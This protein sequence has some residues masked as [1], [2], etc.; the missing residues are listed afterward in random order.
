MA[1]LTATTS[2]RDGSVFNNVFRGGGGGDHAGLR[3]ANHIGSVVDDWPMY[4]SQ[5]EDYI[6]Q[7]VIGLGASS[8]VHQASFLPLDGRACA[9]KVIDLE[10]FGRDTEELRRETQLMSLS[11]HPNVLRVRGCWV[12]GTKLH[13]A[14]RL[15]SSGSLLDIM[16]YSY[17]DGFPEEVIC[18]VLK[19]ALQGLSYLHVNGWLHRDLKAANLLVD[20]DGTVLLGDFGVGVWIGDGNQSVNGKRKSFV[21][22]P[23]WMAPEV[24]ERKLYN[25]KADIWSFG[26]T[27]LELSQGRAPHSRLAPVKVLM[28]TLQEGPPT[29]DRRGGAHKY[30]RA[31]EEFVGLC[32]Q[33]DPEKRP[34]ADKLLKHAF[35]KAAKSPRYLATTMLSQL[36]P[37]SER[38][39][40]QRAMSIASARNQQSW[41][42]GA[43][44]PASVGRSGS[45]PRTPLSPSGSGFLPLQR[46]SHTSNDPFAGFTASIASPGP[47]PWNS[48]RGRPAAAGVPSF[49]ATIMSFDGEHV[50]AVEEEAEAEQ[51]EADDTQ[52]SATP[53]Q[54]HLNEGVFAADQPSLASVMRRFDRSMGLD[55]G[56]DEGTSS[57][58]KTPRDRDIRDASP[59]AASTSP[60][61][62]TD[63][64]SKSGSARAL[65]SPS[66]SR[67]ED[68]VTAIG[69]LNIA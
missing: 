32:L 31:F 44:P 52:G 18:T 41:D 46:E 15:M 55:G 28:K 23:C 10:A 51:T 62:G 61:D 63:S 35:F 56:Y 12:Q 5:P 20:D 33:K 29:L 47:S 30:S 25:A 9:V 54:H 22:T 3:A 38:Q 43:S 16:R 26:I 7:D 1:P 11:K 66:S 37:L 50:L 34:T 58:G 4:S 60:S 8:V 17:A 57:G 68:A 19:Q 36:P 49:G 67:A 59:P 39:E 24:V 48:M 27:A 64:G 14:T 2:A 69:R 42:F 65:A 40:R 21:G 13:I 45:T 6:L 53:A